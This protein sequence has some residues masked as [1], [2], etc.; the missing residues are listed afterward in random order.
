MDEINNFLQVMFTTEITHRLILVLLGLILQ[1]PI[2]SFFSCVIWR[3]LS[4]LPMNKTFK[5]T[6]VL[7]WKKKVKLFKP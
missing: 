3:V 1:D 4:V 7:R 6:K 2:L 5:Q